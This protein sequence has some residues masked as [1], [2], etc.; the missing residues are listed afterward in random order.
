MFRKILH[1]S[2]V[3]LLLL[4]TVGISLN[5]HFCN[6][7]LKAVSLFKSAKSC[8]GEGC[9]KCHNETKIV[10]ITDDFVPSYPQNY[11]S[12]EKNECYQTVFKKIFDK[13]IKHDSLSPKSLC[14]KKI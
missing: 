2:V 5:K 9:S 14:K 7:E 4:A 11:K 13:S 1:I 10:K 3:A 12:N 6:G 8:C